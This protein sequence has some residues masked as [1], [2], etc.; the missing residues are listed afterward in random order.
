MAFHCFI[1]TYVFAT[2]SPMRWLCGLVEAIM[3]P[4]RKIQSMQSNRCLVIDVP[5]SVFV[6]LVLTTLM[7]KTLFPIVCPVNPSIIGNN[8]SINAIAIK[9]EIPVKL[10]PDLPFSLYVCPEKLAIR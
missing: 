9:K 10:K 3:N 2:K 1:T 5:K 6:K 8:N 4:I 7:L